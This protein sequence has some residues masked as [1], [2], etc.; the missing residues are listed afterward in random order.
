M[1][2]NNNNE[3]Q[4]GGIIRF[5]LSGVIVSVV[6][7]IVLILLNLD[8]LTTF[9]SIVLIFILIL[10]GL[11]VVFIIYKLNRRAIANAIKRVTKFRKR[12]REDL[13]AI[14]NKACSYIKSNPKYI[15]SILF[16]VFLTIIVVVL[17]MRGPETRYEYVI[18]PSP[19]RRVLHVYEGMDTVGAMHSVETPFYW[20]NVD[21]SL[22]GMFSLHIL[23]M[24]FLERGDRWTGSVF[25]RNET[26]TLIVYINEAG[27]NYVSIFFTIGN[28]HATIQIDDVT[29]TDIM[30]YHRLI[31]F[32]HLGYI[33]YPSSVYLPIRFITEVFGLNATRYLDGYIIYK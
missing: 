32:D 13:L 5:Y 33:V 22:I 17:F 15:V 8:D 20:K 14:F 1:E 3:S 30:T 23:D 31:E 28:F 4:S 2:D 24:K 18:I 7:G 12:L 21:G 27:D 9:A 19:E 26:N 11:I 6:S 29:I 10:L 16:N 25:W